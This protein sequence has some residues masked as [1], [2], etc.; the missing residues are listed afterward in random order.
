MKK[1]RGDSIHDGEPYVRSLLP[2]IASP[3]SRPA[4]RPGASREGRAR[5]ARRCLPSHRGDARVPFRGRRRGSLGAG[6][7]AERLRQGPSAADLAACRES[8]PAA[9]ALAHALLD[10]GAIL[11]GGRLA[12][13]ED[14][15]INIRG[16]ARVRW[17]DLTGTTAMRRPSPEGEAVRG[18]VAAGRLYLEV[19]GGEHLPLHPFLHYRAGEILDR[20][21][22]LSRGPA[23]AGGIRFLCFLTGEF[24]VPGRDPDAD[25]LVEDLKEFLSWSTGAEI[26]SSGFDELVAG[27][28]ADARARG[29]VACEGR[30]PRG[31]VLGDFEI[32]GELGR[33]GMAV[34]YLAQQMSLDRP[35]ALKLLPPAFGGDPVALARFKQEVRSLSRCDHPNVVKILSS[36]EAQ[37]THYYAMEFID[38]GDLG[39][40]E[41]E[42]ERFSSDGL[43]ALR[44]ELFNFLASSVGSVPGGD[45]DAGLP[46]VQK[47]PARPVEGLREGRDISF[48]LAAVIRDAARGVQHIHDH[49]IVH[50]DLKPQNIMVTRSDHRPVVMDLGLAKV[51]DATR[52]L[53]LDAVRI[54]GTL[55]YMPPEQLQRHLL[56]VDARADV[57]ALGAVLYELV[58]LRPM[59]DGDSE[60]RRIADTD[61]GYG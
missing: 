20:V 60:E 29:E 48:R 43:E 27:A 22:F 35:V 16:E 44:E 26:T 41:K 58:C 30:E 50:R 39:A 37:G 17:M 11:G 51:S 3:S 19:P 47:L 1:V 10:G 56:D 2:G 18:K 28:R 61:N 59:L 14:V 7:L 55:R 21:Y 25:A 45:R 4:L 42:L 15:E 40:I 57:Y 36:G 32:L 46:V 54:L 38:G 53:T 34:V 23:A 12:F 52:S 33:G 5:A 49:G 13:A 31:T 9:L 24:C 6:D 8:I